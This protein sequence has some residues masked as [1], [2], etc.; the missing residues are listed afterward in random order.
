M[1]SK[2]N[3]GV[4]LLATGRLGAEMFK[5]ECIHTTDVRVPAGVLGGGALCQG[6]WGHVQE[7]PVT[8]TSAP[9]SLPSTLAQ[10]CSR[11]FDLYFC[12]VC[13]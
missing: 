7:L 3:C 8:E 9:T 12:C 11:S 4:K 6:S 10:R 13:V 5:S 1:C 2:R